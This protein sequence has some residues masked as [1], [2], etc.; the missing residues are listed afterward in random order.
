MAEADE[1]ESVAAGEGR[2]GTVYTFYSYKGGVG[3]SMALANVGVL[4]A[5][6]ETE[7]KKRPKVLLVDWDLEAPGLDVFFQRAKRANFVG[8]PSVPGVLDLL[9]ARAQNQV[10]PW[11]SCLMRADFAGASLD[12]ISAGSRPSDEGPVEPPPAPTQKRK[13]SRKKSVEI[14]QSKNYRQRVQKLDWPTLFS[15]HDIGNY[16]WDLRNEWRAE[17]DF[18]LIDSRT[19]ITDIGDICTVLLPDALVLLFVSNY[20]NVDGV[21]DIVDRARAARA[22]LPLDRQLL[23]AIPVPSRD[24]SQSEY[25]KTMEWRRIYADRLGHLFA[26]WLHKDFAATDVL[27]SLYLP[28]KPIWS[29]GESLPVLDSEA[30]LKDPLSL[31]SAYS[32]LAQLLK[33][34]LDWQAVASQVGRPQVAQAQAELAIERSAR[35]ASDRLAS[36]RQLYVILAMVIAFASVVTGLAATWFSLRVQDRTE[37]VVASGDCYQTGPKAFRAVLHGL[38]SAP[39]QSR[40]GF[41]S[42]PNPIYDWTLT[43]PTWSDNGRFCEREKGSGSSTL[44]TFDYSVSNATVEPDHVTMWIQDEKGNTMAQENRPLRCK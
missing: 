20:Q 2:A 38:A 31:G 35:V 13:A 3:R 25:Y 32:R 18:V 41:T 14:R 29:F 21:R 12:I 8:N 22:R 37:L 33:T 19:G 43:C 4:L 40:L 10:L 24:E 9:E 23:M 1:S 7:E 44:W 11:R 30:E 42:V 36:T 5:L 15:Q 39:L 6:S 27:N 34:H 28:Y 26:D 17:Y 16:I